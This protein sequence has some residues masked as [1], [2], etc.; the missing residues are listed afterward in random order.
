[1]HGSPNVTLVNLCVTLTCVSRLPQ[2]HT[3][4]SVM[5]TCVMFTCMF[6]AHLCVTVTCGCASWL[7]EFHARQCGRLRLN[8]WLAAKG[9]T[10]SRMRHTG[11]FGCEAQAC[12]QR[13]PRSQVKA[14][15]SVEQLTRQV[16]GF[17]SCLVHHASLVNQKQFRLLNHASF[18]H[19]KQCCILNHTSFF[20]TK[21][22]LSSNH[23]SFINQK[24]SLN[25]S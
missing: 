17:M 13:T 18:I 11:C 1:M 21:N 19:R 15:M 12:R 22:N 24:L 8:E 25:K 3:Y 16:C 7:P 6:H 14:S 4:L 10:P 20:L 2:C 9:R 23:T 5:L